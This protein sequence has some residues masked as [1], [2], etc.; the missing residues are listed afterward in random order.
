MSVDEEAP[1]LPQQWTGR[2]LRGRRVQLAALAAVALIAVLVWLLAFSS[3]F[4]ARNVTVHGTSALST[5]EV[6]AAAR[7]PRGTPLLRLDTGAIRSRVLALADVADAQ[8]STSWPDSVL[9]TVTER[10]PVGYVRQG[11]DYV[12]VDITGKGFHTMPAQPTGLPLLDFAAG[13]SSAAGA[14]AAVAAALPADVQAQVATISALDADSVVLVL[15]DQRT[16]R[17]GSAQ[18]NADKVRVL[19]ALLGQP[20]K[21]IDLTDPDMPYTQ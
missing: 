16:V 2:L 21:T 8:V 4:S 9:I 3:V 20:G 19:A 1:P 5:N 17:W 13:Q 18:R 7:V 10:T 6:I 14:V 12:L 15:T 11:S